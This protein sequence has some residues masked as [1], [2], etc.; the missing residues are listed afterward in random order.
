[1]LTVW[2]IIIFAEIIH[3]VLR[4]LFLVPVV[5]DFESRQIGVFT[6][7]FI[8]LI[9][10]CKTV[11]W[12]GAKIKTELMITGLIWMLLT[13]AFEISFGRI[14]MN[15]AWERILSDF[16]IFNGGL[17]SLGMLF[18]MLSPLIA[19]KIRGII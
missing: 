7:S 13:I 6:G 11:R 18:L 14:V 5:G 17:L 9:I 2:L 4:G 1:V 12:I 10:A 3:G 16:N 8:I 15:S 19:A